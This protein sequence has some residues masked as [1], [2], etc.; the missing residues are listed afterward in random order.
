MDPENTNDEDATELLSIEVEEVSMVDSGAIR[1]PFLVLKEDEDPN[2]MAVMPMLQA[3]AGEKLA[4]IMVLANQLRDGMG[5]LERE[6]VF[7]IVSR[8]WALL[9]EAE[10]DLLI[11][12]KAEGIELADGDPMSQLIN[13]IRMLQH[14]AQETEQKGVSKASSR[15]IAPHRVTEL[16]SVLDSFTKLLEGPMET[17]EE[18]TETSGSEVVTEEADKT[19]KSETTTV[20]AVGSIESVVAAVTK[21]QAPL[22]DAVTKMAAMLGKVVES[23]AHVQESVKAAPVTEVVKVEESEGP[24]LTEILSSVQALTKRLDDSEAQPQGGGDDSTETATITK[25]ADGNVWK[26]II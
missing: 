16:R 5:T 15:K 20:D 17:E 26:G 1:R 11:V 12:A 9:G 10:R 6:K 2:F 24:D 18:S 23:Q 21:A 3:F 25:S 22:L 13:S 19:E 14:D 8:I 4:A 7:K